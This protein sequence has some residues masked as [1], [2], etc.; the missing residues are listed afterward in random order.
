M[1][2]I[3]DKNFLTEEQKNYLNI[4]IQERHLNFVF[5]KDAAKVDDNGHHFI[6]NVLYEGQKSKFFDDFSIILNTFCSKN[7]IIINNIHRIAVNFTFNNGNVYKCPVHEDHDFDH[8]QLLLYLNDATG[9]TIILN[10]K[11]EVFKVS[12]PE[13]FKGICFEKAPHYHYFPITGIR[14][15]AVF[16]FS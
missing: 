11:N 16:T 15:I 13:K 12:E 8:K 3:E 4:L 14:Q 10:N 7:N 1:F 9:D 5:S 6:H 2:Y